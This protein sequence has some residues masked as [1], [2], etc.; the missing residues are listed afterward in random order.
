MTVAASPIVP[1]SYALLRAP[2]LTPTVHH[3]ANPRCFQDI[4]QRY[5][6]L[7]GHRAPAAPKHKIRKG[8][9]FDAHRD[10]VGSGQ[11]SFRCRPVRPRWGRK[12]RSVTRCRAFLS[13]V[14]PGG[15]GGDPLPLALVPRLPFLP[16]ERIQDRLLVWCE[17]ITGSDGTGSPII[18]VP[19]ARAAI[20]QDI[21]HL[22]RNQSGMSA[23]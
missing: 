11:H 2:G 16:R 15:G 13:R 1:T 23:R 4:W 14:S 12:W 21:I 7:R 5:S 9:T 3:E 8:H 10:G 17:P 19:T 6:N 18:D 22:G 20:T